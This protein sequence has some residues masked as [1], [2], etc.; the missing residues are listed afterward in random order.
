MVNII[1][2]L[3]VDEPVFWFLL[4]FWLIFFLLTA[5]FYQ[6]FGKLLSRYIAW[7]YRFYRGSKNP[8]LKTQGEFMKRVGYGKFETEEG[9]K[10]CQKV[11]LILSILCFLFLISLLILSQVSPGGIQ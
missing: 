10:I 9:L 2:P 6:F 1:G 3:P 8:V 4:I 11:V 7:F 5:V